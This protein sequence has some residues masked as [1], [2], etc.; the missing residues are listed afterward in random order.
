[1]LMVC[2]HLNPSVA[3]GPRVRR[4]PDPAVD[5]RRRGHPP[6]P[7]G[8]LDDRLRL[9]GDGP[10][11]R[12]DHPHVADRA[13]DEGA[14]RLAAGRRRRRQPRARR[15]VAKYT[16]CPA[17]AHGLAGEV[18]SV[19]VGKLADLVLWDP[20]F[21]GVRPHAGAEGRDDRLGDRWATPTRRSRRRSRA[22]AAD[23]RRRARRRAGAVGRLGGAGRARRRARPTGSACGARSWPSPTPGASARP[24]CRSTTRCPTSAID[25]D[26]FAVTIDGELVDRAAGRASCRWPSATSCSDDDDVMTMHRDDRP[27]GLLL[28][29]DGRF[30]AAATPSRRVSRR[31][32]A[33]A[34]SPTSRS[35]ERYLRGRL[36]TTGVT[37]RPRSRRRRA[38]WHRRLERSAL[39][40][41]DARRRVRGADACRRTVREISRRSGS[42][43]PAGSARADRGRAR[44]LDLLADA[45]GGP[46]Q[47]V[48][49]GVAVGRRRRRPASTRRPSRCTTSPSAVVTGGR[50]PARPRPDRGAP[51]LQARGVGLVGDAASPTRRRGPSTPRR[52][53]RRRA[54]R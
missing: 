42:P 40:I 10:H 1:M 46:H 13:R 20:A 36:A 16:I 25:P 7:R 5:D 48:V 41:D 18:G 29:A 8:D 3:R 45:D 34:T 28:L 50:P 47:P 19:E 23:V 6:R 2:H 49:L 43:A 24:T 31:R 14:P 37:S 15:Y 52:A 54:A 27:A 32:C 11:R 9:P 26:T 21:F 38:R 33:S 17:I 44:R 51:A 53:A 22:A 4:E 35:L 30:P 39:R 12:G